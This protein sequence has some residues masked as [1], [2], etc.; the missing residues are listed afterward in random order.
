MLWYTGENK[1]IDG[2]ILAAQFLT[3]LPIKKSVDFNDEKLSKS[4]FFFPMIGI[5]IGVIGC[6]FYH[7]FSYL[8][9]SI[10]AFFALMAMIVV[11]GGLH[12][13][14]LSDTC[15]GFLSYRDKNRMLEIMKD[16]RIGAFGVIAIV[17]DIFLKYVLIYHIEGNIPLILGLSYGNSRLIISY[18]MSTKKVGRK[19]GLGDMFH[20]SNP[21][22]YAMLGG[23]AYI[24]IIL[25]I[26][27]VY[28]IPL[29]FSFLMGEMMT[30]ITYRK[31]DGFTGDVYGA[32][33][34]IGEIISLITF[35]GVM[36]W[37]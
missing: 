4:V 30:K 22:K 34:E 15:D 12:L 32:T 18:I 37:I 33:I 1:M 5:I 13:D 21:K 3:R 27:P 25:L 19:G 7:I 26:N 10:G 8:N 29:L 17:L 35:I 31:I 23:V 16:S 6:V 14:G 11:T 24:A 20:S 9:E 2:F 28:L 36:K